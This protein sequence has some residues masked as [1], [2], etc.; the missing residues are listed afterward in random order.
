[1]RHTIVLFVFKVRPTRRARLDAMIAGWRGG[2]ADGAKALAFD[3]LETLHFASV[4][5]FERPLLDPLLVIECN[6]DRGLDAFIALWVEAAA[7]AGVLTEV[8]ACCGVEG[9]DLAGALRAAVVRPIAG[10]VGAVGLS[11][12]EIRASDR[13]VRLARETLRSL[14][15][16]SAERAAQALRS[17]PEVAAALAPF[18]DLAPRRTA[19]EVAAD[20]AG[21]LLPAVVAVA[22]LATAL[23]KAPLILAL[24]LVALLSRLR[25]AEAREP[26]RDFPVEQ[27][28]GA[29]A[30]WEDRHRT[31]QN[32]FASWAPL[33]TGPL[34]WLSF[35]L[36]MRLLAAVARVR[37]RRGSLGPIPSIHF[38]HW[39]VVD[40]GSGMVFMSN[41]DGTWESYLDDFIE[42]AHRGL[43]GVWSHTQGFPHSRFLLWEGATHEKAFKRYARDTQAQEAVWYVAYPELTTGRINSNRAVLEGL[44]GRGDPALWLK[45]I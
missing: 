39:A 4:T 17:D 1:M 28:T 23:A 32:H 2:A 6:F 11:L 20:W 21:L 33:K 5:L 36:F 13:I 40:G 19:A 41:F 45:R 9:P 38:A 16:S 14:D 44:L 34:R 31:A 24:V 29:V 10:H 26:V 25:W 7:E 3:R 43:T 18:R 35:N 15:E 37:Y 12:A 30:G 8:L 42:K 22:L 27:N